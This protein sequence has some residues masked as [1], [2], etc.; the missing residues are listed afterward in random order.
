MLKCTVVILRYCPKIPVSFLPPDHSSFLLGKP[1]WLYELV[2]SWSQGEEV[3][4]SV[5]WDESEF[6]YKTSDRVWW[7][8]QLLSLLLRNAN[9]PTCRRNGDLQLTSISISLHATTFIIQSQKHG[10]AN[11]NLQ[12]KTY[13][14]QRSIKITWGPMG[15][16]NYCTNYIYFVLWLFFQFQFDSKRSTIDTV[17]SLIFRT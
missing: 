10:G 17:L 16:F 9:V 13:S 12:L 1:V 14:V 2:S 6:C 4:T 7:T 3:Y 11:I 5:Y 8:S 15:M